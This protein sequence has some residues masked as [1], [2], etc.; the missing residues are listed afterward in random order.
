MALQGKVFAVTGGASG[1]GLATSKLL[2][3]R[4]ATVCVADVDDS[5]LG[6]AEAIFTAQVSQ[7][8]QPPL[9]Q[10]QQQR[11]PTSTPSEPPAAPP[12]PTKTGETSHDG[13]AKP[14]FE[15]TRVDVTQRAQ[16]DAWV[17]GI[18]ERFG[19]LDGAANIAGVIGRYHS[20]GSVADTDDD[21]EWHRLIAVNL[22]GCMYCL[23]AELKC[24]VDGGS[25]VNM[26]SIHGTNAMALHGAYGAS[27]HGV[28]G[29]TRAAAK[30]V[31]DREIRVNAVAPGAIYTPMMERAWAQTGRP[32]NAPFDESSAFRR[33]GKPEEV[34]AVV[35]FLLGPES[36]FVSGS[37]YAV[38][39]A[40][41]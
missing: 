6:A 26:A 12:A 38:D 22:T 5:A 37:V 40:W 36:T 35:A 15:I 28:V 7:P 9:S 13:E 16:V 8:S 32:T 19:R 34:A 2:L 1:I 41:M 10:E 29:L 24:V 20:V 33:Y 27:K 4:G 39:G 21:E 30:E 18:V 31:G 23:R 11:Q 14:R 25:I 3:E 17:A